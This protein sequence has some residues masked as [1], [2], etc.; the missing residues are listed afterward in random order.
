M[1]RQGS[2]KKIAEKIAE[3]LNYGENHC[4]LV[5]LTKLLKDLELIKNFNFLNYNLIGF[6][7]PVYYFYPPH[8]LFEVF[9]ALPNLSHAK[10]FI[11]CTSGGNPGACLYKIKTILDK[12]GIKIIDGYD[13]WIGLDQHR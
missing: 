1:S 11:F 3:G 7:T 12:K 5:P 10:G 4:E 13:K 2:T 8:H 9:E 6:G